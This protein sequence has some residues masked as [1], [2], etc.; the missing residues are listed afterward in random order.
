MMRAFVFFLHARP[1]YL[2]ECVVYS[3]TVFAFVLI[4]CIQHELSQLLALIYNAHIFNWQVNET[5]EKFD[6]AF[7]LRF[8]SLHESLCC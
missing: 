3:E 4:D 1:I 5:A 7:V 8:S 2:F 6:L